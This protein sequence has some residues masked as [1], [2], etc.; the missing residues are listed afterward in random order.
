MEQEKDYQRFLSQMVD[1]WSDA[2]PPA[3]EEKS[4]F[5]SITRIEERIQTLWAANDLFLC[6]W[7]QSKAE[8]EEANAK[9][10]MEA[11]EARAE[12]ESKIREAREW[13]VVVMTFLAAFALV[14][15][16]MT[17]VRIEK[18]MSK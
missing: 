2:E 10:E 9:A 4:K 8:L 18:N 11:A 12:G 17:L 5:E 13:F 16:T 6:G 1:F 14:L 3:G 15:A 7:I